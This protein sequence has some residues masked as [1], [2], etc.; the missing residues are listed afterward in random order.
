MRCRHPPLK[1]TAFFLKAILIGGFLFK[2]KIMKTNYKVRG[3]RVLLTPPEIK[4]SAI[5]LDA[6][7]EQEILEEQMKKWE[8]LEVFAIG[9][10]ITDIN[11]GDHVYVNPLFLR[12][13]EHVKI[14]GEDKIIVRAP[15]IS[16]V[17]T[18]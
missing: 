17:W 15:D 3:L 6:K 11:V 13:S 10:E 5:E 1:P 4:K 7:L 14:N 8:S 16:I 18:K 2:Q 12:N 9:D